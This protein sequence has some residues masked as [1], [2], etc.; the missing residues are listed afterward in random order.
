MG[1]F[2]LEE[3][4]SITITVMFTAIAKA[5]IA[6]LETVNGSMVNSGS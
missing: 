1:E 6:G 5:V 4:I 3:C 2:E